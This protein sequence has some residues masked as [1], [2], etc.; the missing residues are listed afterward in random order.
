MHVGEAMV[1]ADGKTILFCTRYDSREPISSQSLDLWW[2]K[3]KDGKWQ[4]P[5][6]FGKT[7]NTIYHEAYPSLAPSGD[8][9]FFRELEEEGVGCEIFVSRYRNGQYLSS[10][11]IGSEINSSKHDCDPCISPDGQYLIFCVR[12]RTEGLGKN[13]LY[14]SYKNSDGSWAKSINLGRTIN[15]KAEEITPFLT[16]DGKYLFFSSNRTGNYDIYW[17]DSKII[18]ELKNRMK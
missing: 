1:T 11:N 8:L 5:N 14:I 16:P 2:M 6:K 13:D 4:K 7:V 15:S 17:V 18:E 3:K 10:E 12:D 9:Y